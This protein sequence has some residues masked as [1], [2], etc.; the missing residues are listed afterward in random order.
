MHRVNISTAELIEIDEFLIKAVNDYNAAQRRYADS[1]NP[2]N[3]KNRAIAIHIDVKQYYF[4][5]TPIINKNN[6]KE[7]WLSGQCK[8]HFVLRKRKVAVP[9]RDWKS[10][11]IQSEVIFDGGSCYFHL[12]INLTLRSHEP[13]AVNGQG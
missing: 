12:I 11:S 10:K 4:S 5:L 13:L 2:H 9:D 7:V 6:Q 1:I 8:D 3:R